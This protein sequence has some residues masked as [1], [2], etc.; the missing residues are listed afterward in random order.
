MRDKFLSPM[1]AA[2]LTGMQ[3]AYLYLLLRT[4]R[5]KAEKID[6]NWRIDAGA[7]ER[8]FVS[9]I[10]ERKAEAAQVFA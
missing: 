4:G 9:R 1:D 7:F 3:P 10:A 5:I 6:G 2:R 8:Q